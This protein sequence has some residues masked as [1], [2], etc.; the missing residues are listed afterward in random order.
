MVISGLNML[1]LYCAKEG[2]YGEIKPEEKEN[3]EGEAQ[4][5]Y[6]GLKL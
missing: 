2:I 1:K 3:R 5:N 4:E 6:R